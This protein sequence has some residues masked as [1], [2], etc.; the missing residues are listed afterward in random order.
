MKQKFT[1]YTMIMILLE[2]IC[3]FIPGSFKMYYLYETSTWGIWKEGPREE[4]NFLTL[5]KVYGD[6]AAGWWF[7][8]IVLLFMIITFIVFLLAYLQIDH[9]FTKYTCYTPIIGFVMLM[10][11]SLYACKF[12]S[13]TIYNGHIHYWEVGWLFYI[14]AILHLL[15]IVLSVLIQYQKDEDVPLV[16][17]VRKKGAN[18]DTVEELKKYKELF[19]SGVITQDEFEA[20]KKQLLNL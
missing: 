20:K 17:T 7:S 5:L 10:G 9:K 18:I 8:I 1:L 16:M 3:L 2:T 14:I 12:A 13:L 11:Y 6:N 4:I 19:D 15:A